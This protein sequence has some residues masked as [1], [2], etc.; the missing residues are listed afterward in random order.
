MS[1]DDDAPE[2]TPHSG[3]TDLPPR[4][5]RMDAFK[6]GGAHPELTELAFQIDKRLK[7]PGQLEPD[8]MF[9]RFIELMTK[10]ES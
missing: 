9:A 5:A 6:Q 4:L 2:V 3:Y 7:P 8:K 1:T 10:E